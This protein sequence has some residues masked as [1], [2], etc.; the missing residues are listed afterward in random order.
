[1]AARAIAFPGADIWDRFRS[2]A[3]H[4]V[5]EGNLEAGERLWEIVDCS[6]AAAALTIRSTSWTADAIDCALDFESG[7]LTCAP[8]QAIPAA[9]LTFQVV[10][11]RPGIFR[12]GGVEFTIDE[13]VNLILDELVWVDRS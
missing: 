11:E 3:E 10:R 13:A 7:N 2:S 6:A 8:G 9:P 12:R 4:H 1:M 5:G